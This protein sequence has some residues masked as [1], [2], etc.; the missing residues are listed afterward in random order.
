MSDLLDTVEKLLRLGFP[1]VV[2]IQCYFLW[3][4]NKCLRKEII[5]LL[6]ECL[7]REIP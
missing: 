6:K 1:A 3:K 5:A 4:D 7:R 2:L